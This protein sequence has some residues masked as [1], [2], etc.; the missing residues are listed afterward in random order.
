MKHLAIGS[1]IFYFVPFLHDGFDQLKRL[2]TTL[3]L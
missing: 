1:E 3:A 2:A